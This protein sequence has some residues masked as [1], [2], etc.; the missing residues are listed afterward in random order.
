MRAGGAVMTQE[1]D[2]HVHALL[3]FFTFM[4]ADWGF[5]HVHGSRHGNYETI[6]AMCACNANADLSLQT[7]LLFSRT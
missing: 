6:D 7:Q 3:V 2:E 1:V 4:G 5:H